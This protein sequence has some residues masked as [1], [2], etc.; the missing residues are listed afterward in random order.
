LALWNGQDLSKDTPSLGFTLSTAML[1]PGF[2]EQSLDRDLF[3]HV[4]D[5]QITPLDDMKDWMRGN[6][7]RSGGLFDEVFG[8]LLSEEL[9]LKNHVEKTGQKFD[10][11]DYELEQMDSDSTYESFDPHWTGRIFALA[12]EEAEE[13]QAWSRKE[14]DVDFAL[15]A[16]FQL[17]DLRKHPRMNWEACAAALAAY[18]APKATV[19]A[20]LKG[21][22]P[23]LELSGSFLLDFTDPGKTPSFSRRNNVAFVRVPLADPRAGDGV[24]A[25][26]SLAYSVEAEGLFLA[27]FDA[28]RQDL[29]LKNAEE[30]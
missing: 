9:K 3:A 13:L 16:S 22:Q 30:D 19:E 8:L 1:I 28:L 10:P 15:S 20:V 26:L 23:K 24:H 17:P 18:G 12:I 2:I 4:K 25:H 14:H 5:T 11:L 21:R 29:T 6:P 27:T 7:Y